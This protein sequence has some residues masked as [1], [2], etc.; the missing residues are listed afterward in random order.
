[1]GKP[2]IILFD[3][4]TSPM[5]TATFSLYPESIN[6]TSIVQDW[7]IMSAAWKTLRSKTTH[8]T[9][10][11]DFKRK[12]KDDDYGVVKKLREALVDADIIIGHNLK[13]FD[14]K[15][16]NARIIFH[17]LEPLPKINVID[18][19]TEIKKIAQFSSHRLDYLGNHLVGQGKLETSP[20]LWLKAMDGN[21]KAVKELVGYNIIDVVRL[22]EIYLKI[23][24]Y[25]KHPHIGV[26]Q[27]DRNES[28]PNCGSTEFENYS[29]I[30]YT[31]SGIQKIQ[32]QCKEC[33]SYHTFPVK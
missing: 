6:H 12:G 7:F 9:S 27:S 23:R 14:V 18:T 19:L 24:S 20:G 28:C 11:N 25:I 5:L 10:I 16:L 33:H 4:E 13:K 8:S 15:K 2:N 30:R 1:M 21:R 26:Y 22:E 31:I 29:K 3:I 17:G 32:K